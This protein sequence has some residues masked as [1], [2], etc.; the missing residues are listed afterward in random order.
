MGDYKV[1]YHD[2]HTILIVNSKGTIRKLQTPFRVRCCRSIG[3]YREGVFLYVDA[4]GVAS[5]DKLVYYI[6]DVP[7]YHHHFRVVADF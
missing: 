5:E 7:Y 4:V 1:H 3:A 6:G 2:A